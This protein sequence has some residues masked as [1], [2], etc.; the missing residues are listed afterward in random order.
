MTRV[1]LTRLGQTYPGADAP[2]LKG[3]SLEV[4]DGELCA[5]LGPSG[6][7]KTTAMR[8]IAGLLEPTEGDIAFDGRSVLRVPPEARGAVMVFQNHLL[9]PTMSVARNV[10]FGL[11]MRGMPAR[12]IAA[13]SEAMLERVQLAGLGARMPAELS[14]GQRQRV[15]LARALVVEPRVLLLDEPLSNLDPHLRGEMRELILDLH[16]EAGLTT[17]VVTHD[18]EE[19]VVLAGRIAL[20]VDG[21]LRQEGVPEDFYERPRD[22]GVARFFG[23]SN[24]VAGHSDGRQFSSALGPL[25]LPMGCGTG[26]GTLT[27]RP[28]A[29]VLSPSEAEP[30]TRR[31]IVE[32]RAYLGTQVRLRV[33]VEGAVLDV[34]AR[35]DEAAGMERGSAIS[36]ALPPRALWV[37][38]EPDQSVDGLTGS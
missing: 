32:E 15:A 20:L 10:G 24:L 30:N 27:I 22:S 3:L 35:P 5:L 21:R 4:A 7:G 6:C 23:A 2:A 25:D 18:Q 17:I 14:G 11:R 34:M 38:S 36:I 13:R 29:I 33:R 12:E 31:A 19:A 37:M 8:M 1:A 16:R 28:E 26:P 9:F